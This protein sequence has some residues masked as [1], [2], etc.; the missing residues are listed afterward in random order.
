M[1]PEREDEHSRGA[2]VSRE[3]GAPAFAA[4]VCHQSGERALQR[5]H[6]RPRAHV[7]VCLYRS[8]G[9]GRQ[10]G[11]S[12]PDY[13]FVVRPSGLLRRADVRGGPGRPADLRGVLQAPFRGVP[14]PL[15]FRRRAVPRDSGLRGLELH[16]EF[17]GRAARPGRE[18]TSERVLRPGGECGP[19]HR[20]AGER[21][22]EQLHDELH[23]GAEPPD[24]EIVRAG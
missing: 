23:D 17:V 21:G 10:T 7:G 9:G 22:R 3:L 19:R 6:H 14:F 18:L 11:D 4:V 16:W 15:A 5:L 2:Y 1:V 20:D 8:A 13:V 24:H 12:L